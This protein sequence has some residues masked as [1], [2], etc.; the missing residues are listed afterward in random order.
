MLRPVA[1]GGD[2]E[3]EGDFKSKDPPWGEQVHTSGVC[4]QEDESPKLAL[5]PV[6]IV[7]WLWE[8]WIPLVRQVHTHF[9]PK[10]GSED[11]VKFHRLLAS[12]LGHHGLSLG[13]TPAPPDH[14]SAPPWGR[15][16][17]AKR[18]AQL[19]D[20]D[21]EEH[22]NGERV[23]ISDAYKGRVLKAILGSDCS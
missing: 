11:R 9:L 14:S 3:E 7:G 19:W 18:R 20:S 5:G 12:L 17:V 6:G 10:R 23:A 21:L 1:L 2:S 13:P 8:A 16:S 4:H 22:M 15:A